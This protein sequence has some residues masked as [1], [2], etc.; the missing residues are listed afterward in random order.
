MIDALTPA[1]APRCSTCA[2]IGTVELYDWPYWRYCTSC[3]GTGA[4]PKPS[5]VGPCPACHGDGLQDC[6]G[7][8]RTCRLCCGSGRVATNGGEP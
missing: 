6:Y 3:G 7:H 2:G 1:P 8:T 5:L 4:G